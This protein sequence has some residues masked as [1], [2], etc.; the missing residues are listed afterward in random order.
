MKAAV[1]RSMISEVAD[2]KSV[3][4]TRDIVWL[5]DKST[6]ESSV[7]VKLFSIKISEKFDVQS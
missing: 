3:S 2:G 1:K 7:C 6:S 4:N 5:Q